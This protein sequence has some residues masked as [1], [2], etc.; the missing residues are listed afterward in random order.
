MS[1]DMRRSPVS[2]AFSGLEPAAVVER[3]NRFV[4]RVRLHTGEEALAH[5]AD[6][7][8]LKELIFPGNDVMVRRAVVAAKSEADLDSLSSLPSSLQTLPSLS[9]LTSLS[10]QSVRDAGAATSGKRAAPLRSTA[11]DL[12]L[13]ATWVNPSSVFGKPSNEAAGDGVL[14]RHTK[15]V[16]VSVDT[17][18]PNLLFGQALRTRSVP[19]IGPYGEVFSEHCY[20]HL[21][22]WKEEAEQ[23][24]AALKELA[25]TKGEGTSAS[26]PRRTIR[27]RMDFYLTPLRAP[28]GESVSNIGQAANEPVAGSPDCTVPGSDE[29]SAQ[30]AGGTLVEVKSVTLCVDGTGYFPDAP[31]GRGV[32][33]LHEL[34]RGVREGYRAFAVFIAQREDIDVIKPNRETDKEFADALREARDNGVHLLGLR[35]SVGPTEISLLPGIVPVDAC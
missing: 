3:R 26:R 29:V 35:C 28:C 20:H 19:E 15:R 27:S 22:P 16:W 25:A 34:M 21:S 6:S 24:E 11:Y 31:T 4:A 9:S 23:E 13:A 7:G 18:Y 1:V 32:R 14:T 8:R 12:V 10:S 30:S 5:I 17:R 2:I 33:H